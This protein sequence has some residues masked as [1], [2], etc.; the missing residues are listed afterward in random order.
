[1]EISFS[2]NDIARISVNYENSKKIFK[3]KKVAKF[4]KYYCNKKVAMMRETRKTSSGI[5]RRPKFFLT[6][7]LVI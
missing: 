2:V 1:M 7:T 4:Y 5:L 6:P 3:L